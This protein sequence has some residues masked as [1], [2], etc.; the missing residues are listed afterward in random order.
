MEYLD[1]LKQRLQ[2]NFPEV[3]WR[4]FK[5]SDFLIGPLYTGQVR[6]KFFV[7]HLLCS[8]G[9]V[10]NSVTYVKKSAGESQFYQSHE[11]EYQLAC[12]KICQMW[13]YGIR[14]D[15]KSIAIPWNNIITRTRRDGLLQ[16]KTG[17]ANS[18]SI[19]APV[20]RKITLN[21]IYN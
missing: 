19:K 10:E 15:D 14:A 18:V 12:C 4:Y 13:I 21:D 5:P 1:F 2:L 6:D 17:S 3:K 7:R 20:M 11:G 8:E 9:P 16:F